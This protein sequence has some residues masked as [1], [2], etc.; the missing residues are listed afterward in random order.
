MS[1]STEANIYDN[2]LP[3]SLDI[4]TY[5][6]RDRVPA[7]SLTTCHM[8][9][10]KVNKVKKASLVPSFKPL[11]GMVDVLH[12]VLVGKTSKL[13][14]HKTPSKSPKHI[15]TVVVDGLQDLVQITLV[16]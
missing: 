7:S 12:T 5:R 9:L 10:E 1:L 3:F 15:D 11:T 8:V 2:V 16:I 13:V 4:W 14:V 6:P